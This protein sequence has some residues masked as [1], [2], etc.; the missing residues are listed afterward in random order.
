VHLTLLNIV[1]TILDDT[2]FPRP[3][4][5]EIAGYAAYGSDLVPQELWRGRPCEITQ[6]RQFGTPVFVKDH[7]VADK[8]EPRWLSAILVIYQGYSESTIRYYDPVKNAFNYTRDYTWE[9]KDIHKPTE[10]LRTATVNPL[11]AL[12]RPTPS[13]LGLPRFSPA[14]PVVTTASATR[15]QPTPII[16][17]VDLES[18]SEADDEDEPIIVI[19][20]KPKTANKYQD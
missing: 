7:T 13:V 4:W 5:A 8:L 15:D 16:S 20:P 17:D 19:P 1:R 9:R 6:L 10:V 11:R 12:R 18:E 2:K 3:F 14:P